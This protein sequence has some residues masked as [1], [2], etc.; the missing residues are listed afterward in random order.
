MASAAETSG[1]AP[2]PKGKG[3]QRKL[4]L[5]NEVRRIRRRPFQ[6]LGKLTLQQ[7]ALKLAQAIAGVKEESTK[8][9]VSKHQ[10]TGERVCIAF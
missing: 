3:K 2:K 4:F 10:R 6:S 9:K 5:D 1:E 7:A 8:E